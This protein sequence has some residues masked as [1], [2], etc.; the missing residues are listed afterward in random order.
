MDESE[1]ADQAPAL[2][3]S[4]KDARLEVTPAADDPAETARLR[5]LL[6]VAKENEREAYRAV[7]LLNSI[8]DL[9]PVVELEDD[10]YQF[11]LRGRI[12]PDE[13]SEVAAHFLEARVAKGS[14]SGTVAVDFVETGVATFHDARAIHRTLLPDGWLRAPRRR[15][16]STARP[17]TA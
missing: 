16:P 1:K 2:Q 10:I 4:G 5:E 12:D 17:P 8:I 15:H 3:P 13:E 9:L 7:G 6:D 14:Y 11:G